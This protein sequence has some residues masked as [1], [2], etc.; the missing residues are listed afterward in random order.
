MKWTCQGRERLFTWQIH[1]DKHIKMSICIYRYN[2]SLLIDLIPILRVSLSL[3]W[4]TTSWTCPVR[5]V[6]LAVPSAW[7]S[8][9][10]SQRSWWFSSCTKQ[11]KVL[12]KGRQHRDLVSLRSINCPKKT[13]GTWVE[14]LWAISISGV[15]VGDVGIGNLPDC[16]VDRRPF[17]VPTTSSQRNGVRGASMLKPCDE[18]AFGCWTVTWRKVVLVEEITTRMAKIDLHHL[19]SFIWSVPMGT[20]RHRQQEPFDKGLNLPKPTE[21]LCANTSGE[22]NLG[23]EQA[24]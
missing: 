15:A 21:I 13:G 6:C 11:P 24:P 22:G 4:R 19:P 16:K 9:W 17:A 14:I 10:R 3:E 8:Q 1:I 7:A 20:H 18:T 2:W 5:E 23:L 12:R